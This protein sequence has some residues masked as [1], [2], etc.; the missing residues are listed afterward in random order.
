MI[1]TLRTAALTPAVCAVASTIGAAFVFPGKECINGGTSLAVPPFL[2][3]LGPVFITWLVGPTL[4]LT[5]VILLFLILRALLMRGED[6]FHKSV[7][8]S[9]RKCTA[10]CDASLA[11]TVHIFVIAAHNSSSTVS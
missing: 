1:P 4:A 11:V 10:P 7:W 6:P 9:L 3:G 8:V 2:S 5:L